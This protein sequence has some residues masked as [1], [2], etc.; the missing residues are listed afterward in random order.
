MICLRN[1]DNF[2]S[3]AVD[4]RIEQMDSLQLPPTP[5]TSLRLGQIVHW[6]GDR[7][8]VYD[9]NLDGSGTLVLR[10]VN[11]GNDWRMAEYREVYVKS[12]TFTDINGSRAVKWM[13]ER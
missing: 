7:W 5:P 13:V 9:Y 8:E 11:P 10:R 2:A 3:D 6:M 1:M 4:S 12:E